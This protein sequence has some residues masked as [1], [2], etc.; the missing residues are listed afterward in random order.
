[1]Q[2]KT[3]LVGAF[4]V[5]FGIVSAV[6]AF[7]SQRNSQGVTETVALVTA[8][9]ELPRGTLL[10]AEHLTLTKFPASSVPPSAIR[11]VEKAV[12]RTVKDPLA[13]GELLLENRLTE[14]GV[15]RGLPPLIPKGMR[16]VSIPTSNISSGVTGFVMPN[17]KVDVL[18]T[19]HGNGGQQDPT[20]GGR[21]ITLLQNVTVLA[22][23]QRI[24]AP[25]EQ[26]IDLKEMKAVT[27]LVTPQ[28]AEQLDLGQ[29]KGVLRLTLRNPLD[30][31][32]TPVDEVTLTSLSGTGRPAAGKAEGAE[33]DATP[34]FVAVPPRT[35][36]PVHVLTMRGHETDHTVV[37]SRQSNASSPGK[38]VTRTR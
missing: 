36:R 34:V 27:L 24:E 25:T 11:E 10:T 6:G 3:L 19:M 12:G 9:G 28:Q 8:G 4:A 5:V 23:D 7:I 1:M 17:N 38:L 2:T 26:K 13:K 35:K 14:L 22:V 21:T 20:G 16:A 33:F 30:D 32:I 37:F 29:N 31:E 18:L 15:G